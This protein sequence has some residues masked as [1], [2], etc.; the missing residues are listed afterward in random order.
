MG[1]RGLAKI[2]DSFV[3]EGWMPHM[4]DAIHGQNR[5]PNHA[6]PH[7]QIAKGFVF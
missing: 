7:R 1:P 3:L 4:T 6:L 2:N 5:D